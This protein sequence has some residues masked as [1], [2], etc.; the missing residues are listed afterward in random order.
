[1]V[2][3]KT[4]KDGQIHEINTDEFSNKIILLCEKHKQEKKALAFA[5]LGLG[6]NFAH[7]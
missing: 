4:F 2:P 5:F 3:V 6:F 7:P 1:M